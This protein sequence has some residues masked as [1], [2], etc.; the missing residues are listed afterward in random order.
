MFSEEQFAE[1]AVLIP[2]FSFLIALV[3]PLIGG[4]VAVSFL[5]FLAGQGIFPLWKIIAGSFFGMILLDSFWFM[6][7]RS[8]W[9]E[10]LKEKARVSDK[11]R[12]LEKRVEFFSH[13]NDIVIL[14]LSKVLIGT[15]ILILAYLSIRKISFIR[16]F[17][18]NSV[19]TLVWAIVL[20]YVG[21]FAG[22]GYYSLARA[23]DQLFIGALYVAGIAV[24]FYGILWIIRR[25]INR[26]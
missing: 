11:Y 19:A 4:E 12:A 22:R 16:F 20:G 1:L 23:Q 5:A 14:I 8:R 7:P 17:A 26:T 21:W 15:R 13:N 6:V 2:E 25:W 9:G 18:Y 10:R 3:A 24:A